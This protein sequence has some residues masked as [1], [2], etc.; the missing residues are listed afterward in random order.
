MMGSGYSNAASGFGTN[1]GYATN[2]GSDLAAFFDSQGHATYYAYGDYN[3]SGQPFAGM[4]EH[5][6]R[7]FQFGQRLRQQRGIFDQRRQRY[8]RI[9][10]LAGATPR[11]MPTRI[12]TIAAS[13]WPA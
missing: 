5:R 4:M 13:R 10:R 8:G 1:V 7:L 12:T 11:S 9:L 2:G 6:Q 3:N